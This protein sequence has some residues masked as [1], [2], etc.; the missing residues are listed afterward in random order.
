MT[1]AATRARRAAPERTSRGAPTRTTSPP[2]S[3]AFGLG[4]AHLVRQLVRRHHR[5]RGRRRAA[6]GSCGSVIAHEPPLLGAIAADSPEADATAVGW[7]SSH[8]RRPTRSAA[9]TSSAAWPVR[10][11]GHPRPRGL[12]AAP[13]RPA[14]DHGRQRADLPGDARL[15]GVVAPRLHAARRHG[16]FPILLS[17]GGQSPPWLPAHVRDGAAKIDGV[18]RHTFTTD[19]HMPQVTHPEEYV[20][21]GAPLRRRGAAAPRLLISR[22]PP[23][24]PGARARGRGGGGSPTTR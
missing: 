19:G 24:A 12:A 8:G 9:A 20:A 11:G 4:S 18:E 7:R 10:R 1:V 23:P 22:P 3:S 21:I 15:A 2:S 13:G 14:S 5:A 17:D 16:A 6:R